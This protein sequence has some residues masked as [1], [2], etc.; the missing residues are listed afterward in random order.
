[1]TELVEPVVQEEPRAIVVKEKEQH[2]IPETVSQNETAGDS[3]KN[4]VT[5]EELSKV[6]IYKTKPI[7]WSTI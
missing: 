6:Y 4:D 1:M 2:I 7:T 3:T 5:I